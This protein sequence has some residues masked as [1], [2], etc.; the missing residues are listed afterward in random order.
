MVENNM[1]NDLGERRLKGLS[2]ISVLV[3]D[4]SSHS[5]VLE[6]VI[7]KLAHAGFASE[8]EIR[9]EW[10]NLLIFKLSGARTVKWEYTESMATEW[11]VDTL[12]Q[13]VD[14][15]F[16]EKEKADNQRFNSQEIALDKAEQNRDTA[17]NK[18]EL[19]IEKKSDAVYVKLT[20]LQKAFSDVMLRPE[21]E[22]RLKAVEKFMNEST[23]KSSGMNASWIF[24]LGLV[25]LIGGVLAIISRF[26]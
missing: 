7:Q 6:E 21:I 23:G 25:S 10:H 18:A 12:K 26:L 17:I 9:E 19:S 13:Y 15:R 5:S 22:G 24:V 2:V 14:T 8:E 3:H 20:D 4:D 1:E 16:S 11:T